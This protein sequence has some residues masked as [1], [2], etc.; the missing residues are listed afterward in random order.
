MAKI[1]DY[2]DIPL[3]GLVIGRAQVRTRDVGKGIDELAESIRVHGL[4]EPILVAP[5]D[6]KGKHEI[7]LGQR[8]FLAHVELSKD[9]ITAGVLDERV[10][11][12]T[13]KVLSVTENLIRQDLNRRD[14]TD[15]CT[16]LYKKY[17]TIKAV[18]EETGLPQHKVSEYVKYDRLMPE[19]K[20]LVDHGEADLNAALRAQNAA[21]AT[22]EPDPEDAVMLAKEMTGMS[23][24]QR[25]KIQEQI[26]RDPSTSVH[27]AIE[28]A[29]SGGRIIQIAVTLLVNAHTALHRFADD[30]GTTVDD[31]AASLI[32]EGLKTKGYMD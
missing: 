3:G 32:E 4:L 24:A 25:K 2:R 11:E 6:E 20:E 30:E 9:T 12:I 5:P 13:A 18:V 29:K 1:V 7:I 27:E 26:E 10:D 19:L 21:E 23:G 22:G 17:G 8:R 15:V 31:A 16:Y 28:H 14:L